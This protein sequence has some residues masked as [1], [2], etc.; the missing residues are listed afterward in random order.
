MSH[1]RQGFLGGVGKAA[2]LVASVVLIGYVGYLVVSQYRSRVALRESQFRQLELG[3]ERNASAVR[4]FL[5]ERRDDLLHL[6]DSREISIYH[7]NAALG[8]S[9]EYGLRASLMSIQ[10]LFD[11]LQRTKR[12]EKQ[13][14]FSR[15]VLLDEEGA[16]LVVSGSRPGVAGK[17]PWKSVRSGDPQ[18]AFRRSPESP[19]ETVLSVPF[20]FKERRAGEILA[21]IPLSTIFPRLVGGETDDM[22]TFL[23]DGPDY[24]VRPAEGS[25]LVPGELL[26][27]PPELP[28]DRPRLIPSASVGRPDLVA[29]RSPIAETP[30]SLVM[31][32]RA[33]NQSGL[34]SPRNLLLASGSLAILVLCGV[35][36]VVSLNTRNSVLGARLEETS[37]RE[38]A[39]EE[40][41]QELN[42]EI[43]ERQQAVEEVRRLNFELSVGESRTRALLDAL[44]DLLFRVDEG[45]GVSDVHAGHGMEQSPLVTGL[46]SGSLLSA[47]PLRAPSVLEAIQACLSS[48]E[49][50]TVPMPPE[51]GRLE[52][53][54]MTIVPESRSK[55]IVVARDLTERVQLE[56]L[57]SDFINR[58]AHELRTPLTTVILMADLIHGGGTAEELEEYWRILTGQLQRQRALVDRLLTMGRL[59][60]GSLPL[61]RVSCDLG[62]VLAE[63]VGTARAVAAL[64]DV[65]VEAGDLG[66]LPRISGDPTLLPQVFG[67]LLDNAV[68]FTPPGGRV[69]VSA[70]RVA[71]GVAVRISDTGIG[72]PAEDQPQLFNRFFRARNAVH[73]HV[74]G[75]GIGLY[76]VKSIVE[77]SGG[78]VRVESAAGAGTTVEVRLRPVPAF[79]Q[80]VT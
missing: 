51:E 64:R 42:A 4:Y 6:A 17:D 75:S 19:S 25:P 24:L 9:M 77:R 59:E 22:A 72:I 54:E 47:A 28:P 65:S 21:W 20:F 16:P 33:T 40:K 63:S 7:E 57:K 11:R 58:A 50:R 49:I 38:R 10:E 13:A 53:Y 14:I 71:D 41:N 68:K 60:A 79:V 48:G 8:M 15:I 32:V 5:S 1:V 29:I 45:G 30:F 55:A 18:A 69:T 67:N 80:S 62:K 73:D 12:F 66:F 74:P 70:A 39:V 56:Q 76:V 31:F 26:A 37:L 2:G 43:W 27:S 34:D 35:L 44:P 23:A 3:I 61:R 78:S 46:D 36:A 52:H